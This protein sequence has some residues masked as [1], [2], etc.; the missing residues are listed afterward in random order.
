MELSEL[1]QNFRRNIV[2][3]L[4]LLS[5]REEQLEYQRQVPITNVYDELFCQWFDDNYDERFIHQAWFREAFSASEHEAMQKFNKVFGDISK[6]KS[7][8]T[9]IKEFVKTPQW[10]KMSEAAEAALLAFQTT[11]EYRKRCKTF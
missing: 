10:K 9:S 11:H 7:S 1:Q 2:E 6:V 3:T 8:I 4:L 5:S